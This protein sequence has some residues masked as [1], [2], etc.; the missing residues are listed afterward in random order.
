MAEE[1][2]IHLYE[3]QCKSLT[4]IRKDNELKDQWA[5]V[6]CSSQQITLYRLKKAFSS[7][8]K[9][10]KHGE[11][12]GFPRF[13][14]QRRMTSL[15]FK[16]TAMDGSSEPNLKNNG[17]PDD[18][19]EYKLG[20]PRNVVPS[21]RG[22]HDARGKARAAGVVIKAAKCCITTINGSLIHLNVPIPMCSVSENATIT[23]PPIGC[24]RFADLRYS[25][26]CF[27]NS[28][29]ERRCFYNDRKSALV[30]DNRGPSIALAQKVS[31]RKEF[32]KR[33]KKPRM[34]NHVLK[35]KGRASAA[36]H[37]HHKLSAAI[38]A[39]CIQFF[40]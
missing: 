32:S 8:F 15:G 37:Q 5:N 21:R 4:I 9:R 33:W 24:N 14:N 2:T 19:G 25:V 26:A 40:N 10:L 7:F 23:L 3:D 36:D 6:N 18:F 1:Q 27:D 28:V 16:A 38:A 35:R 31:R 39:T 34:R 11:T 30:Q 12:P 22:A 20:P 17:K 13:K 29:V